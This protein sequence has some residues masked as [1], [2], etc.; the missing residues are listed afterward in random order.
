MHSPNYAS[1]KVYYMLYGN[2]GGIVKPGSPVE[3]AFGNMI[4]AAVEAK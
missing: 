3:V 1:G 2:A 4:L